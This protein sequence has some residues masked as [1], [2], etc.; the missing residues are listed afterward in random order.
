MIFLDYEKRVFTGIT[1]TSFSVPANR[2]VVAGGYT[3]SLARRNYNVN[4]GTDSND[5]PGNF[6]LL[7]SSNFS[8]VITQC[9]S[10]VTTV[11]NQTC[12]VNIVNAEVTVTVHI[13]TL[14][15][16]ASS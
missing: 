13:F 4:I 15:D 14:P 7:V 1:N 6:R 9:G 11:T 16:I 5:G 12:Y 2:L 8:G 10:F 3:S